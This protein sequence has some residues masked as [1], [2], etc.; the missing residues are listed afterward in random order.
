MLFLDLERQCLQILVEGGIAIEDLVFA[1]E[2]SQVIVGF[3]VVGESI[4]REGE[5]LAV[6]E[7]LLE[8]LI[9]AD[10]LFPLCLRDV[11]IVLFLAEI[12]YAVLVFSLTTSYAIHSSLCDFLCFTDTPEQHYLTTHIGH[13]PCRNTYPEYS[14]K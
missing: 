6:F 7:P 3:L 5:L 8:R 11:I 9:A 13:H 10:V 14:G 1:W 4:G 2:D 12:D